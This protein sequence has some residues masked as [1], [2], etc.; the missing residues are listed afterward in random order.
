MTDKAQVDGSSFDADSDEELVRRALEG[1]FEAFEGIVR[2]YQDKAYRL[3]W[4]LVK[5]DAE[6]QDVLQEAFLNV[7]RKLDTFE[8]GAK[9]SSWLYRVVVNAALMRLR[10]L[11]RRREVGV[12]DLEVVIGAADVAESSMASWKSRADEAAENQELRQKIIDAIDELE[13]KYQAVFIL[14]EIEGMSLEEIGEVL[15]LSIPAVKTRLHR[16]RLFLRATLE[17]YLGSGLS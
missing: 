5:D 8:G 11:R 3:A 7:Y 10:K 6:A 4:S 1:D 14:K 9:F 13:P 15:E 2:R 17:S 12:D 16:A